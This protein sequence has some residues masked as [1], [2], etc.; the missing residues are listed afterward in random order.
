MHSKNHKLYEQQKHVCCHFLHLL[1]RQIIHKPNQ[2]KAQTEITLKSYTNLRDHTNNGKLHSW[3]CRSWCQLC[4]SRQF[5]YP[6][7]KYREYVDAHE[8]KITSTI[9]NVQG[10]VLDIHVPFLISKEELPLEWWQ[11]QCTFVLHR[12][13][14][15][16]IISY[17]VLLIV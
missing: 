12:R 7:S 6:H 9:W 14:L 10:T 4:Q 8:M 5:R 1:K 3:N 15:D 13:L 16:I 11:V 2:D 17:F